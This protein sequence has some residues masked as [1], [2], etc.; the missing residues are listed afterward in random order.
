ML[1]TGCFILRA[2]AGVKLGA[3]ACPPWVEEQGPA[4]T[5]AHP[6]WAAPV[7][8][9]PPPSPPLTTGVGDLITSRAYKATWGFL[10]FTF[11]LMELTAYFALIIKRK[12]LNKETE[13]AKEKKNSL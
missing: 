12:A 3:H 11:F 13:K 2:G 6:P 9:R 4:P 7:A 10:S 8:G 1:R 5:A